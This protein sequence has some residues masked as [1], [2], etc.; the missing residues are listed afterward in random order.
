MAKKK[1]KR[2]IAEVPEDLYRKFKAK[3]ALEGRTIRDVIV[4]FIKKYL[5]EN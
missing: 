2:V 1:T 3:V 4:E 5:K